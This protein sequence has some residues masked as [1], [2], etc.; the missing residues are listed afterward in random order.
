MILSEFKELIPKTI[1]KSLFL[2]IMLSLSINL[3]PF[4]FD[5]PNN[6]P[7]NNDI[8]FTDSNSLY[9]NFNNTNF[10]WNNEYFNDVVE[11]YTLI[12]Y[13]VTPTFEYHFSKNIKVEAGI[14]LLQYS[15]L[16]KFTDA[17]PVYRATYHNQGFALIMGTLYGTVNH[18]LPDPLSNFENYLTHKLEN[19]VQAIWNKERFELDIWLDWQNFIFVDDSTQEKLV[20]GISANTYIFKNDSWELS[21]PA[22]AMVMHRGGQIDAS[23]A[24][25]LTA[26]N[27]GLGLNLKRP[28]NNK[29]INSVEGRFNYLGFTDNSPTVESIFNNGYGYLSNIRLNHKES[30]F[31]LG[32]WHS[33]QFLSLQGHPMY[34]SKSVKG[35]SFD[36]N[37]RNLFTT[38][39]QYSKTIYRGI[40]LGLLGETFYDVNTGNFDFTTGVSLII[41]QNFFLKRFPGSLYSGQ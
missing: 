21:A 20:A 13:H 22:Y 7:S 27:Y 39:L 10:L 8:F 35:S 25:M 5:F 36:A 15:G 16:D 33:E 11:G 34:Q 38:K 23:Q 1:S 26:L 31:Q 30:F 14:H 2:F 17:L 19:G 41:K 29:I 40:Y 4:A 18:K 9:F 3:K 28:L 12:G 24:N 32:Y 6:Y 37:E